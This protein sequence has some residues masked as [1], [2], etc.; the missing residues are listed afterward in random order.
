MRPRRTVQ[1][2]SA[3]TCRTPDTEVAVHRVQ[4]VIAKALSD[5]TDDAHRDPGPAV[6]DQRGI[7]SVQWLI[8]DHALRAALEATLARV[9]HDVALVVVGGSTPERTTDA[10]GLPGA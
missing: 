9:D 10:A 3:A 5:A 2:P 6:A 7:T 1:Q 4:A 8:G